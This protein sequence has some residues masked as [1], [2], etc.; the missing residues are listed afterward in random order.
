[1][2]PSPGN[3]IFINFILEMFC[4]FNHHIVIFGYFF[5]EILYL[6]LHFVTSKNSIKSWKRQKS[7]ERQI[8]EP[9]HL[10]ASIDNDCYSVFELV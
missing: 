5:D 8:V 2:A 7:S 4:I 9:I 10:I 1:M 3:I 6:G